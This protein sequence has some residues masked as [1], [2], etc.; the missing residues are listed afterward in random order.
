[1]I[2]GL[3][4]EISKNIGRELIDILSPNLSSSSNEAIFTGKISTMSTSKDCFRYGVREIN[5]WN[6]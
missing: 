3:T 6:S 1:M 5:I 2:E 4:E